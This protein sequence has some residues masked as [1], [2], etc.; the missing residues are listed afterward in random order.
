MT[1]GGVAGASLP[2]NVE[3]IEHLGAETLVYGRLPG[4]GE[5]TA[6][7]DGEMNVAIGANLKLTVEP[8]HVHLFDKA[9]GKRLA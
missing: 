1:L 9:S 2:L 6:R 3:L 4:G 8:R 7:V 5:I